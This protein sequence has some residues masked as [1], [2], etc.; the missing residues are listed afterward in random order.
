[1]HPYFDKVMRRRLLRAYFAGSF[2]C[3]QVGVVVVGGLGKYRARVSAHAQ[4][5]VVRNGIVEWL[6]K[7]WERLMDDPSRSLGMDVSAS[8]IGEVSKHLKILRDASDHNSAS[9]NGWG[10]I[11]FSGLIANPKAIQGLI[12]R[13]RGV[14]PGLLGVM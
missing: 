9:L 7:Q 12:L 3:P 8:T 10:S 1:M 11:W 4:A 5:V 2:D 13:A 6:G 14:P